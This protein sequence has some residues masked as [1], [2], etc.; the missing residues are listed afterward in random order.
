[1]ADIEVLA[2]EAWRS[3]AKFDEDALE[4]RKR[5][6]FNS[7][8]LEIEQRPY[9]VNCFSRKCRWLSG[10]CSAVD[11]SGLTSSDIL[12]TTLAVQLNESCDL[13]LADL[14]SL[15]TAMPSGA[16]VK[17]TPMIGPATVCMPSQSRRSELR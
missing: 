13:L 1:L 16:A 11:S 5:A 8:I 9:D 7:E 17:M 12:D 4:I 14:K 15:R 3:S 6:R 2:C 10:A